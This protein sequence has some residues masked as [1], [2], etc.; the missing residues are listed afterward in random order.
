MGLEV[1]LNGVRKIWSMGEGIFFDDPRA[2]G[3]FDSFEKKDYG[4]VYRY[5]LPLAEEGHVFSRKYWITFS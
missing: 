4:S 1:F 5:W 3:G 2:I